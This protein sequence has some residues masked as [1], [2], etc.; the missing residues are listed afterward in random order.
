MANQ[1]S[2]KRRKLIVFSLLLLVVGGLTAVAILKKKDVVITIQKEKVMRRNLTELVVANGKIQPVVQV[3][4]SPEVSGEI[5]ELP[6][7]EGALV[8]KGELL[9]CIRPDNYLATRDSSFANYKY[10]LANSNTAAANFEKA[11]LEYQRSKELFKTKL[12]SDSDYLTAKTAYDVAKA[13]LAGAA[14]QVGMAHASLQNA[15]SDLS[16]T[17]IF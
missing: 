15:E 16:K 13:S 8:K 9:V 14:E 1:K 2:K 6:F 3:K 11:E 10:S 17:K 7:K 4:I 5:L 12:I